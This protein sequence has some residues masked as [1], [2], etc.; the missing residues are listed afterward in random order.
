MATL[1]QALSS[2]SGGGEDLKFLNE[3]LKVRGLD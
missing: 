1:M 2:I 3:V